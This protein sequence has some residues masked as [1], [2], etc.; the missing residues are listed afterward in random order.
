MRDPGPKA[1]GQAQY[2]YHLSVAEQVAAI[3]NFANGTSPYDFTTDIDAVTNP[4]A[5]VLTWT[6]NGDGASAVSEMND[7][8]IYITIMDDT[9]AE[10]FEPFH[11]DLSSE[12]MYVVDPAGPKQHLPTIPLWVH[13]Y[14]AHPKSQLKSLE[15]VIIGPNDNN[16]GRIGFQHTRVE[17]YE[18]NLVAELTVERVGGSEGPVSVEYWVQNDK[19][20]ETATFGRDYKEC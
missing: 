2:F 13:T 1:T 20:D 15:I 14:G 9:M 5:A 8:N 17:V 11:I 4:E 16:P 18:E 19:L 10:L 3:D 7:K 6:V 12:L